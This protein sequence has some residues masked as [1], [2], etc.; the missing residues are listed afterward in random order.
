MRRARAGERLVT[1]DDVERPLTP[2]TVAIA[3][4]EGVIGIA[5]V[6]G[7]ASTEVSPESRDILLEGAWWDPAPDPAHPARR[8][9]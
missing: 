5:G 4:A 6:M 3:D 2:E 8:S 9:A 7:G 1:L